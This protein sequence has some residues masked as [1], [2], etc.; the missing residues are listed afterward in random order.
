MDTASLTRYVLLIVSVL[1]ATLT[2]MGHS[3]I[4]D[5]T[6]NNVVLVVTGVYA[7]YVGFKNNY[8]TSKGQA[9]KEVLE[10]HGLK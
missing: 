10:Q 3:V 4:T 6:A 8:L 9:Q 1:N 5:E 2:M 7:L